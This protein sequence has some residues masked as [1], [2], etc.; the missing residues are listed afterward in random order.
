MEK[1]CSTEIP[2]LRLKQ[3][4]DKSEYITALDEILR[5]LESEANQELDELEKENIDEL[6][7]DI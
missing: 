4:I 2:K 1:L 5:S 3:R 6:Y 7:I